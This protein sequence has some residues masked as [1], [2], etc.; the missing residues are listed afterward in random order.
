MDPSPAVR[1]PTLQPAAEEPSTRER[2]DPPTT[3]TPHRMQQDSRRGAI[4]SNPC[5]GVGL[6]QV[7]KGAGLW[8]QQSWKILL[9]VSPLE[10]NI[11]PTVEALDPRAGSNN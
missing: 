5:G 9:G 8:Q 4:K 11:N 1:T 3:D 6:Q 10:V 2:R 7:P